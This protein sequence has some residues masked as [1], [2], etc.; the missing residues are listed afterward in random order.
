METSASKDNYYSKLNSE[1]K[2][3]KIKSIFVFLLI[4]S[5]LIGLIGGGLYWQKKFLKT[6]NQPK[7]AEVLLGEQEE[8]EKFNF[9]WAVW[10]DDAG[11]AFEYPRNLEVDI[12]PDDTSNYSFLT[13]ISQERKGKVDIYCNDTQYKN[14]EEWAAKDSLVKQGSILDA[15]IASTSGKK[16]AIGNG[17]E[18]AAFIDSDKV[19][20]IIDKQPENEIDFWQEIYSRITSSFKLIPLKGETKEEFNQWLEGFSTLGIDVVES[21][22]I[23]Q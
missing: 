15:K 4:F 6:N 23:I 2:K 16:A 12:H 19:I 10:E 17:R 3:K 18:L 20:Y 5:V 11:F 13:F 1:E 7:R 22:E 14:I 9:D 8:K 21:V